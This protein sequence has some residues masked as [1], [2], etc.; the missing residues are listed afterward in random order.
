[1]TT[2]QQKTTETHV[3]LEG[4]ELTYPAP[5]GALAA[6]LDRVVA[7][8]CDPRVTEDELVE[9]IYGTDNPLLD[10]SMFKDRGAVTREVF[11]NPVYHVLLDFLGRKR[12]Q[13]GTLDMDAAREA[14]TVTVTE[15]ARQLGISTSAVRQAIHAG[16]LPAVKTGSQWLINP[17]DVELYKPSARGPAAEPALRVR[18]GNVEGKSLRPK[19]PGLRVSRAEMGSVHDGEAMSFQLAAFAVSDGKANTLYIIEPADGEERVT[20]KPFFVRGNFR[21]VEK[22]TDPSEASF[23]FKHFVPVRTADDREHR[24]RE[25]ARL[26]DEFGLDEGTKKAVEAW[27]GDALSIVL[28]S[29]GADRG[30]K[31]RCHLDLRGW[32]G[33]ELDK[34]QAAALKQALER[35]GVDFGTHG[36]MREH[37]DKEISDIRERRG[38]P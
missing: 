5:T 29:A 19:I 6:F 32:V 37:Q 18:F 9:L 24:R 13:L 30:S 12:A 25:L 35:V 38:T 23:R 22:V 27:D 3:T 2:K 1:M 31:G 10:Q 14:A 4:R 33:C 11:G 8:S 28:T 15:A 7:M 36:L 16:R 21:V 26:V 17:R 20:S 34:R